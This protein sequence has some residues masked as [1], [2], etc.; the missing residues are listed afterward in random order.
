MVLAFINCMIY[1]HLRSP[2]FSELFH[3]SCYLLQQM[4][5]AAAAPLHHSRWQS[6]RRRNYRIIIPP[7]LAC[8]QE[9]PV[10]AAGSRKLAPDLI[11]G[12]VSPR[13]RQ[14]ATVV[15]SSGRE[16]GLVRWALSPA[17]LTVIVDIATARFIGLD[18]LQYFWSVGSRSS[19]TWPFVLNRRYS[20]T[21]TGTG[22]PT[23][24]SFK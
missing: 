15:T 4:C 16:Y 19:S 18:N 17:K 6:A 7:V 9:Y 13:S 22:T 10:T 1:S 8:G 11:G 2:S 20:T 12:L 23:V 5:L 3:I 24:A 14:R 21:G